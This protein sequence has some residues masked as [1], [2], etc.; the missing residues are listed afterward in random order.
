MICLEQSSIAIF[1]DE[2]LQVVRTFCTVKKLS[3]SRFNGLTYVEDKQSLPILNS[4][5]VHLLSIC[6]REVLCTSFRCNSTIQDRQQQFR[7]PQPNCKY[8]KINQEEV[9]NA[10]EKYMVQCKFILNKKSMTTRSHQIHHS[11]FQGNGN[12]VKKLFSVSPLGRISISF[13]GSRMIAYMVFP[14]FNL[15]MFPLFTKLRHQRR[16]INKLKGSASS[17]GQKN[18]IFFRQESK[19]R[20]IR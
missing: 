8:H 4:L 11:S 14:T 9:P 12:C 20:Q 13:L 17:Q 1:L 10:L 2:S 18:E 3:C 5:I 16:L 7:V 6:I 15:R 19:I